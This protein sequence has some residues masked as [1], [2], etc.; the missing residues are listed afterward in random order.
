MNYQALQQH[1][2]ELGPRLAENGHAADSGDRFSH[3][4]YELLRELKLFSAMVPEELG[5][6]NID[7]SEMTA[8]VR[9]LACQQTTAKALEVCGGQGY[10]RPTGIESLLRDVMAAHFHAM[11]EKRQLLFTGSLAL[12][13]GGR[14]RRLGSMAERAR[15]TVTWRSR[16]AL[17]KVEAAHPPLGR[18]LRNG[19]NTGTFCVYQPETLVA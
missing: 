17:R 18:H 5:G 19:L 4:N 11:Q 15:S 1:I 8:L 14:R 10:L 9:Q 3:E 13:L 7:Y 12:G 2:D 16:Y 6:G